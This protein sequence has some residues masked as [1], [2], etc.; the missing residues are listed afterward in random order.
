MNGGVSRKITY[1]WS[2]FH[3]H[4]WLPEGIHC[5]NVTKTKVSSVM[6]LPKECHG[7]NCPSVYRIRLKS[8]FQL[9]KDQNHLKILKQNHQ[10]SG[11]GSEIVKSR[12]V[13]LLSPLL[14]HVN[15]VC[16]MDNC[17]KIVISA[18]NFNKRFFLLLLHQLAFYQPSRLMG[19]FWQIQRHADL[20]SL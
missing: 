6:N 10:N 19:G 12:L 16:L 9:G 14:G 18:I 7:N 2:I 17:G 13:Q 20:C 3:C 1:K 11:L 4:V 15:P 8:H 5:C